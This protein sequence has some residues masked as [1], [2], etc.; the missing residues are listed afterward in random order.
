M[1]INDK[2][3]VRILLEDHIDKD[4]YGLRYVSSKFSSSLTFKFIIY[5]LH[6]SINSFRKIRQDL[7]LERPRRQNHTLESICEHVQALRVLFPLAGAKEM[8]SL[9][10][11]EQNLSV[12]R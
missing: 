11:H 4:R 5:L 12:E 2:E 3:I 6:C 8:V 9:L 7:G 10:F 1:R